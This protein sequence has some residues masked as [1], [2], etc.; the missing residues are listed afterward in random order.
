MDIQTAKQEVIRT[1][2]ALVET[3]LVARTWGNVSCRID[4]K[5]F[6]VTPSGIG[7]ERL[8]PDNVVVVNI[9]TLAYVG[10]IN[11][12]SESGI[13]AAVFKM[14]P[15]VNFVIHTHQ[16]YATCFSVAGFGTLAPTPAQQE[17]LR[18][19]ITLSGYGLPGS[20]KLRKAVMAAY[21][22]DARAVIMQRHGALLAGKDRK[23]AFERAVFL[24]DACRN[25]MLEMAEAHE[26]ALSAPV[27]RAERSTDAAS[28]GAIGIIA[29]EQEDFSVFSAL[30][31]A[32][33][34]RYPELRA[35]SLFS[36]PAISAQ[37]A[38]GGRIPALLDDFAQ[39]VGIDAF[40]TANTTPQTTVSK[41]KGRGAVFLAGKGALCFAENPS[42]LDAIQILC[43]KNALA[44][45][46]A[47][48]FGKVKALS[49]R[50]RRIMRYW[51]V[52]RYSKKR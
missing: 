21:A 19:K 47:S 28:P 20:R 46:H 32:A 7:Y 30:Y 10:E 26:R 8:T 6:A 43:E 1:A 37:S 39:I 36:T 38:A 3:G 33:F 15:D 24:E 2:L 4:D 17:H 45:L 52:N 51:Y 40:I 49:L 22:P 29:S 9:E 27:L 50:D 44:W 18:T 11:P 12:S 14:D 13:H 41:R 23:E 25:A 16:V 5:Y 48:R 35:V 34:E 31:A 42:D